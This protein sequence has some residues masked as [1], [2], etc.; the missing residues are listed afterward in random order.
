MDTKAA[1]QVYVRVYRTQQGSSH[2]SWVGKWEWRCV[3]TSWPQT[4]DRQSVT[5][6]RKTP[7]KHATPP[8]LADTRSWNVR[9]TVSEHV[10]NVIRNVKQNPAPDTDR[11]FLVPIFNTP[12]SCTKRNTHSAQYTLSVCY[13]MFR[14]NIKWLHW[15]CLLRHELRTTLTLPRHCWRYSVAVAGIKIVLGLEF[16]FN[17]AISTNANLLLR[18]LA[19]EKCTEKTSKLWALS[20]QELQLYYLCSLSSTQLARNFL[21]TVAKGYN[22]LKIDCF[23]PVLR[24]LNMKND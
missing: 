20:V 10:T 22:I 13:A 19:Q 3:L 11:R 23:L 8:Q 7:G 15:L 14:L 12:T 4:Q 9:R 16:L 5:S 6:W 18:N 21:I 2:G 1:R 17:K 24:I